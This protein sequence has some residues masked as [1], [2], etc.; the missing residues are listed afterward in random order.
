MNTNYWIAQYVQDLFKN[1]PRNLA[2]FVSSESDTACKFCGENDNNEIDGR[3][4][5]FIKQPNAYR[6]WVE[7]WKM[8]IQNRDFV[9]LEKSSGAHYRIV[10]GGKVSNT[11]SD[12]CKTIAESLFVALVTHDYSAAAG[13]LDRQEPGFLRLKDELIQKLKEVMLLDGQKDVFVKNPVVADQVVKGKSANHFPSFVQK[14][15]KLHVFEPVDFTVAHKSRAKDHAGLTAY[16]FQDIRG[17]DSNSTALSIVKINDADRE[18][19]D[20]KYGLSLI[21]NESDLVYWNNPQQR[22][23][24]IRDR[25]SIAS[26]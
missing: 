25:Q 1:E 6:Q 18:H 24:F 5:R 2:V 13:G 17:L 10:S 21:E 9:A 11:G 16:M 3:L 12:S 26:E 20:V 19:K 23:Q 7:Y 14:N 15:G 22:S 8:T 4:I